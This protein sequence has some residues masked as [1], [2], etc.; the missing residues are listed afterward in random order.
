[1]G[2]SRVQTRE[3]GEGVRQIEGGRRA[4]DGASKREREREKKRERG[5]ERGG[6]RERERRGGGGGAETNKTEHACE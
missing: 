3:G 4:S 1:M 2:Q 6:E 5:R